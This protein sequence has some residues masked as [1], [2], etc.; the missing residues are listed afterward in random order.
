MGPIGSFLAIVTSLTSTTT[1]ICQNSRFFRKITVI[2]AYTHDNKKFVKFWKRSWA[3]SF[4][5]KIRLLAHQ[6]VGKISHG[7]FWSCFHTP[8]SKTL[9]DIEKFCHTSFFLKICHFLLEPLMNVAFKVLKK[10]VGQL[11]P[12]KNLN[13][14]HFSR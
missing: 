8:T 3:T 12:S 13:F 6:V 11:L 9:A 5:P 2:L 10:K 7:R 14:Y 1:S 4:F